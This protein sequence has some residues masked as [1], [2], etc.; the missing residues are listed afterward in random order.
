MGLADSSVPTATRHAAEID[1]RRERAGWDFMSYLL[2]EL[3]DCDEPPTCRRS[4]LLSCRGS[5]APERVQALDARNPF[6]EDP[7]VG[8]RSTPRSVPA[9]MLCTATPAAIAAAW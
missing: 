9:P 1:P 7:R 6:P 5:C 2:D 8:R 4:A 3:P